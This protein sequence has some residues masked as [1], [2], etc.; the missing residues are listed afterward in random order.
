MSDATTRTAVVTG[1]LSGIGRAV[2][3]ALV[4]QD[5]R[6]VVGAR[7]AGDAE[8]AAAFR[9]DGADQAVL[10]VLDVRSQESVDRFRDYVEA[11]VGPVDILVNSAGMS[12]YQLVSEHDDA[13]WHDVLDT[14]LNGPFRMIRAFLP[15]MK[16]RGWG[17]IVNVASTAARTAMPDAAAYCASKAGLLGLTRAVALEGAPHGVS[18]VAVSPTWVET[19]MVRETARRSASASGRT[20]DEEMDD[21]R[22]SNPQNRLV[23][24]NEVAALI[25]FLCGSAAGAVTMED[26]QVNAGAHW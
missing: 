15:Q 2:V 11:N 20:Y 10:H 25:A 22:R 17:R 26:I 19:D 24:A 6:V 1:G 3:A 9:N 4:A 16:E 5:V 8:M 12:V 23:Q 14:N 21:L 7:R 18:C 13:G